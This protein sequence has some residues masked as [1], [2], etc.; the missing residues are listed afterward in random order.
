MSTTRAEELVPL[1]ARMSELHVYLKRLADREAELRP[2]TTALREGRAAF[3]SRTLLPELA[4]LEGRLS[5]SRARIRALQ[6]RAANLRNLSG[7]VGDRVMHGVMVRVLDPPW[8]GETATFEAV[9]RYLG[10]G[11][12]PWFGGGLLYG[13]GLSDLANSRE[14]VNQVLHGNLTDVEAR[15][16]EEKSAYR[17][18][19]DELRAEFARLRARWIEEVNRL[20]PRDPAT[21]AELAKVAAEIARVKGQVDLTV[22]RTISVLAGK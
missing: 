3:L 6:S 22:L 7:R 13:V 8:R 21:S 20:Y 14:A 9:A 11:E 2:R 19:R 1:R 12:L 18:A 16:E 4:A 17:V 5:G 10:L 15:L